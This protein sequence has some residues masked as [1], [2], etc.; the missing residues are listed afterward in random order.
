MTRIFNLD[1]FLRLGL[2]YDTWW[3]SLRLIFT[4]YDLDLDLDTPPPINFSYL[5]WVQI[6]CCSKPDILSEYGI[7]NINF[8]INGRC[9]TMLYF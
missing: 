8:K 1:S 3:T 5:S 2:C 7:L 9:I 6:A 4:I